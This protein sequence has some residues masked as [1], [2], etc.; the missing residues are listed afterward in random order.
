MSEPYENVKEELR[1]EEDSNNSD[2]ELEA[3]IQVETDYEPTNP[4]SVVPVSA[5]AQ[6]GSSTSTLSPFKAPPNPSIPQDL[7]LIME[8]V[9]KNEVVGSLP[10]I[11]MS[12]AEKRKLVEESLKS[13]ND[14]GKSIQAEVEVKKKEDLDSDSDSSSSFVSSS[15]GESEDENEDSKL[16][17][18]QPMNVEDHAQLQKELNDFVGISNVQQQP[19]TEVEM[20][21][22]FD[23]DSEEDEI[24]EDESMRLDK[25]GFEFMEDDEDDIGPSTSGP[26]TSIH[27]APLPAV[28]QPP[29]A[30][31]PEGEGVSLAGD[32]VSWMKEKKVEL[33]LE[34]QKA[35]EDE[36]IKDKRDESDN[37]RAKTDE[38]DK[39][40]DVGTQEA[41]SDAPTIV[42]ATLV[43]KAEDGELTEE[44]IPSSTIPDM[45]PAKPK[46]Q[47]PKFTSSGTVVVRAMQS[48]PGAADEGWLEEG[49]VLC[50]ED[51]RVLGTVHETFGPLTSPFYTIRLPP[52]PHP[53]PSPQTLE[54]GTK[55][56]YPLNPSYRSFVNMLAV[57]DPR[58][59]GS[60]ASNIY[61]EEIGEDEIEWSDDEME[62]EAKKRRKQRKGSKVPPS[63]S[64]SNQKGKG[65]G[66]QLFSSTMGLPERPHFDYHN[67]DEDDNVSLH[68]NNVEIGEDWETSS[69]MSSR[70]R[71][72]EPYDLDEIPSSS[73]EQTRNQLGSDNRGSRGRGRGRGQGRDRGRGRGRGGGA[74]GGHERSNP[75]DNGPRQNF[76][77]P[78]NPMMNLNQSQQTYN[79]SYPQQQQQPYLPQQNYSYLP[80]QQYNL[81][82]QSYPY[83]QHQQM[84]YPTQN[85]NNDTYEPTQPSSGMPSYQP[86]SQPGYNQYIQSH[87][88]QQHQP[89]NTVTQ[90]QNT[91]GVPAIN[92]R[93]AA[94]YSQQM[95]N[96][97]SN[98]QQGYDYEFQN[99]GHHYSE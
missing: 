65:K 88:Y 31:L 73:Q 81:P 27:E 54:S 11:S 68:G 7:S 39:L 90:S 61:D 49:S 53:Y 16:K 3:A 37:H 14:Q 28:P 58:F 56:Y 15:E 44:A 19:S 66:K 76:A 22:E 1:M 86:Q 72:L 47:T 12:A 74:R 18:D 13:R 67:P 4:P 83:Q 24:A 30:K 70:S 33:W 45:S 5:P 98:P 23:S 10:P 9:S 29:L 52:P 55:L 97:Q 62:A 87:Q 20:D 85:Y 38:N 43:E 41:T 80:Q 84:Q 26:I 95:M 21:S 96:N 99:Q 48:R 17:P 6:A 57:R 36:Q 51:G 89:Q 71:N 8:M 59:K 40:V 92:P 60:D 46:D 50:W 78:P 2:A 93:F 63:N 25:L 91:P 82:F 77:L 32:V 69:I 64:I 42:E 34:K 35:Q 75:N 94:Q 79:Q